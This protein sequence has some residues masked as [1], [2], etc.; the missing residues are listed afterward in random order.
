M[1]PITNNGLFS[2]LY[3]KNNAKKMT[4]IKIVC[5]NI[6]RVIPVFGS[7]VTVLGSNSLAR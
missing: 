7:K 6:A 3:N 1:N 2:V 5:I 4:K